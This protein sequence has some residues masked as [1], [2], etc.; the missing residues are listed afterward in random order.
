MGSLPL[1][2]GSRTVQ[3]PQRR[4]RVNGAAAR[5]PVAPAGGFPPAHGRAKVRAATPLVEE[6]AMPLVEASLEFEFVEDDAGGSFAVSSGNLTQVLS[7]ACAQGD[8]EGAV[9]LYEDHGGTVGDELLAALATASSATRANAGSMF[10]R[11]R[12]FGRAAKMMLS[13]RRYADAAGYFEQAGDFAQA[14]K[15]HQAAGDEGRAAA[16]DDRNGQADLALRL[17]QKAGAHAAMADCLVRHGRALEAADVYRELGNVRG[18]V[19]ALRQ[20]RQDDPA[21][22]MAARRL[23]AI[24]ERFDRVADATSHLVET[25]RT[26]PAARTDVELVRHLLGLFEKQGL[27]EQAQKLTAHLRAIGAQASAAAPAPVDAADGYPPATEYEALKGIPIFAELSLEDMKDL[28]RVAEEKRFA[29]GTT[30]VEAD[31]DSPGLVVLAEGNAEV[32]AVK[33]RDTRLLN[34]LGPGSYL[35]EISLLQQGRTSARVVAK[36]PIRALVVSREAFERYH[37][38]HAAASQRIWRLFAIN[39]ADRVRALSTVGEKR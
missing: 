35:G 14:A 2:K 25:M 20:V 15:C 5:S 6:H 28:Y 19:E 37:Y 16:A 27:R 31:S 10:A 9:R 1:K 4:P 13:C 8:L 34:T 7:N 30:M 21:K 33:G 32:F 12:D 39:L 22:A 18:E 38:A 23:A 24:Y 11:A 3:Y 17:Y 26:C 29:P 36:T